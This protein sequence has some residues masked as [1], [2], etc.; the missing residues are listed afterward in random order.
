MSQPTRLF[1]SKNNN[2][3]LCTKGTIK[4]V[5]FKTGYTSR[6]IEPLIGIFP[7]NRWEEQQTEFENNSVSRANKFVKD[8]N[9]NECYN[10]SLLGISNDLCWSANQDTGVYSL[11]PEFNDKL[12]YI[13]DT[14]NESTEGCIFLEFEDTV[15]VSGVFD[16]YHSYL[17]DE[18]RTYCGAFSIDRI[19]EYSDILYV[20]VDTESG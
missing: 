1:D 5:L 4:Y 9:D 7:S 8:I 18:I 16:L 11:K 12:K 15:D 20:S 17:L 13:C 10:I 6:I 19:K 2:S 3:T 14:V